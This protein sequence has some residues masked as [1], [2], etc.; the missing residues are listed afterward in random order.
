MYLQWEYMMRFDLLRQL[1]LQLLFLH[2]QMML[3]LCLLHHHQFR[4]RH[5]EFR[6]W[7]IR[8]LRRRHRRLIKIKSEDIFSFS[9][10]SW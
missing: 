1:R 10:F 2:D 8:R 9:N 6:R 4:L 3:Y 7:M 5:L